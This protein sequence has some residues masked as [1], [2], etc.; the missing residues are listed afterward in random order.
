MS[1][2]IHFT[3][4]GR[5]TALEVDASRMLLW[6]LRTELGLTG[7]KFGCGEGFCGSCT[8]LVD[9]RAERSCQLPVREAAGKE[10]VTIEG[11]AKNGTLHPVQAAFVEHDALQCG[12]CTPGMVLSACGLLHT[13][14]NPSR[15]QILAHLENNLCRC[16]AHLRIV[17][18]V[19]AAASTM[20]KGVGS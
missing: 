13:N 14:P 4:N 20:R 7:T 19:Q 16:G 17:R 1:E 10:V 8:V 12:F 11:L 3:L 2:S 15:D 9:G 6:V 5:P 18:A